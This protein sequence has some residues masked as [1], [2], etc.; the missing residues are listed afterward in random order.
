MRPGTYTR[1]PE[2]KQKL[3][4]ALQKRRVNGEVFGFEKDRYF[5]FRIGRITDPTII[6]ELKFKSFTKTRSSIEK[7]IATWRPK[8]NRC[9]DCGKNIT[10]QAKRCRPCLGK[11]QS[12][13][14]HPR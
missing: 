2:V 8:P 7:N 5:D 4:D 12:G 9:L 13:S 1:T 11:L 14:N 3:R 10:P 6:N